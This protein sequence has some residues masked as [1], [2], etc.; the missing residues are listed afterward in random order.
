MIKMNLS[1]YYDHIL[2]T[3]S[4]FIRDSCI[5]EAEAEK[6]FA[7][8]LITHRS[9]FPC[10]TPLFPMDSSYD[11]QLV[12][13]LTSK[14]CQEETANMLEERLRT[15]VIELADED[16]CLLKSTNE[17]NCAE[18][19]SQKFYNVL[20][21]NGLQWAV[22]PAVMDLFQ[23]TLGCQTEL[24]A[25]PSNHRYQNYYS[26]FP[27]DKQLG[28]L[29]NFFEAPMENF[30][31][32]VFQVNPPFID[33]VFTKTTEIIL[34]CLRDAQRNGRQLT[35]IYVM[36]NWSK[37]STLRRSLESEFCV[38]TV[39]LKAHDHHYYVYS[40]GTFVKAKFGSMIIFL[41]TESEFIQRIKSSYLMSL[42]KKKN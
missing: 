24:F 8:W 5:N 32:G 15:C 3:K 28:S 39:E 1:E 41:S 36:P 22:P 16:L 19:W 17:N 6:I 27:I 12:L 18:K 26:L 20:G 10:N 23:N 33:S 38:K 31:E 7:R 42:F 34:N 29:G 14:G 2:S 11:Y 9:L 25:S 21:D 40:T 35:F 37:F 4:D 30:Q 13:E